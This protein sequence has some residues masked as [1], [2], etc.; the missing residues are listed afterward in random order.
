MF[1]RGQVHSRALHTC[2]CVG[3]C[4]CARVCMCVCEFH[5]DCL[6]AGCACCTCASLSRCSRHFAALHATGVWQ[7]NSLRRATHKKKPYNST[8]NAK[9]TQI[10]CAIWWWSAPLLLWFFF[11]TFG[12]RPWVSGS[13]ARSH[14]HAGVCRCVCVR[15]FWRW[16]DVAQCSVGFHVAA[17]GRVSSAGASWHLLSLSLSLALPLSPFHSTSPPSTLSL[18]I[19]RSLSASSVF[20]PSLSHYLHLSCHPTSPPVSGLCVQCHRPQY[21]LFYFLPVD[22]PDSW[23]WFNFEFLNRT[24]NRLNLNKTKRENVRLLIWMD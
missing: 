24:E 3:T 16:A 5:V 1:C 12:T 14:V 6:C 13:S 8:C 20:P 2:V 23:A 4:M 21:F 9:A 22:Q 7:L 11:S 17:L 15:V 18:S 19:P 10:K